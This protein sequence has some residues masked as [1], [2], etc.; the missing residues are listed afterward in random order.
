MVFHN[1]TSKPKPIGNTSCFRFRVGMAPYLKA[2]LEADPEGC[3]KKYRIEQTMISKQL[4]KIAF[5]PDDWCVSFKHSLLPIWPLRIFLP[6]KLPAA[7]KVVAF[8]G[9]PDVHDVIA[10]KWPEKKRWKRIYK[11]LRAPSWVE[12]HWRE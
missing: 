6:A 9:K 10:G 3:W 4:P 12:E 8:T 7:T 5:W 11:V 1:W 2:N